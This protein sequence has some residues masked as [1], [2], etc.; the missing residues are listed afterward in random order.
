MNFND[1]L[2]VKPYFFVDSL[3]PPL[4]FFELDLDF[5]LDLILFEEHFEV[6]LLFCLHEL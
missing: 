3:D 6:I 1:F 2:R 5:D 4:L